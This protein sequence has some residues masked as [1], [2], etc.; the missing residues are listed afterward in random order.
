MTRA[1]LKT[2]GAN[3]P[4]PQ[5]RDD[6][7]EAV[8][9]IGILNRQIARIEADLND[10]V[11]DMKK[12][13]EQQAQPLRDQVAAATEGLKLWAEANRE[14]LTDGGRVKFCDL[15]T[16]KLSW[17]L[18][19]PSVRLSRVE[20]VIGALKAL[21]LQ[22]FLRVKEEPNKEAMLAEPDIARTVAGVTIGSDGEDF[23]VEPF[24]IELSTGER[25]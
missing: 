22:R 8:K 7:A 12:R 21:G 19:P 5:S 14:R 13:A 25:A 10:Q 20:Q 18:R 9:R 6:A 24:E 17:R 23:I 3:L 4:V 16:G 15:G 1:R 2:R 11:I